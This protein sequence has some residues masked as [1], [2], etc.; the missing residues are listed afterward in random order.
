MINHC[1]CKNTGY[2]K[3]AVISK[4]LIVGASL[5]LA[6]CELGTYR[7]LACGNK[8]RTVIKRTHIEMN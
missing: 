6:V 8:A 5:L 1:L 4:Q 2:Y 3:F 7:I